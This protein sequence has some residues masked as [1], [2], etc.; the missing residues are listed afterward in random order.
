M[1]KKGKKRKFEVDNPISK[2][3][4]KKFKKIDKKIEEKHQI[5]PDRQRKQAFYIRK[6]YT[7]KFIVKK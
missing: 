7:K 3:F 5:P 1:L 2:I 6:K 4:K